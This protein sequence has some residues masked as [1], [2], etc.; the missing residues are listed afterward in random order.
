MDQSFM[1]KEG[2]FEAAEVI[3]Q[4]SRRR[5]LRK[6]LKLGKGLDRSHA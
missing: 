4:V 5:V 3:H 1:A 6:T 2:V